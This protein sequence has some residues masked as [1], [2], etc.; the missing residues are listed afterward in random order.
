MAGDCVSVQSGRANQFLVL[1]A[2]LVLV[3]SIQATYETRISNVEPSEVETPM[4]SLA[5]GSSGGLNGTDGTASVV[6]T[7]L[8]TR[9]DVLYLNNTN[10]TG[11]WYARLTSTSSTGIANLVS[12][13][14]GIDN[15]TASV[16]Q[17][18]GSLGTLTQKT[19]AY[20]RLEP[21]SANKIYIARTVTLLAVTSTVTLD[22]RVAD[23]AAES[24]Y[25]ITNAVVSVT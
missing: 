20:V 9:T 21:A 2:A 15:G 6:G 22:V 11:A 8:A 4:G 3:G 23:D 10:A 1:A 12:L 25:L 17:V 13:E 24:A 16:A 7:L 19:G 14:L 5:P 18:I